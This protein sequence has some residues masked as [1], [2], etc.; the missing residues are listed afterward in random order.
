MRKFLLTAA[1]TA[2]G[3]LTVWSG[4]P[5]RSISPTS[6]GKA[7]VLNTTEH[8]IALGHKTPVVQA[9]FPVTATAPA[10]AVEVPFTHDLGKGGA[11]VKNYTSVNANNDNRKWQYGT[12]NG[13]CACMVPN[14]ADIEENDDWLF[15]VPIHLPAGSYVLGFEI[16][17]MGSGATSVRMNVGMGTEPTVEAMT[18]EVVGPTSYTKKD[19]TLYEYPVT[20]TEEGYYYLGF[21]CTTP[22]STKGTL[23]LANLSMKAGEV[24]TPADPPAA[25]QLSWVLA[26]KGELKATVTYVAPTK[27]VSG[28]DLTE[29]SKVLITSRWEV[30]K[31]EYTDVKP[32]QTIVIEDVEMYAGINNRFTAVAYVGDTPGEKVEYKS[33]WCG[34]DTPLA[35]TNV[36]LTP[37]DDYT[38]A[39]LTWDPVGEVGENGGYVDPSAVT[40]YIFD[41][42]G[43]YYDPAIAVVENG[44]TSYTFDYS[45]YTAQDFVAYQ[46]TAGYNDYYSL[47]CASN[48]V[49]V[50]KP[51][52]MPFV[53]SFTDGY[54]QNVWVM[55]QNTSYSGQDYGTVDDNYFSSLIDP[56]DPEAPT[57]L[58]SQDKDN[59][60]FYWM[61]IEKDV[62]VGMQSVR[63]NISNA[64]KPVLDFWYQGQGSTM[65]VLVAGGNKDFEVV[66]TLD[67][68]ANPTS[69]WTLCRIPLDAYKADGCVQFAFRLNAV[70]NTDTEIWSVPL[71][72]F[73]VRDLVDTDLRV[74]RMNAPEK[75]KVGETVT[76]SAPIG[77]DGAKAS[78]PTVTWTVN[79]EVLAETELEAI[80]ADGFTTAQYQYTVPVNADPVLEFRIHVE[81]QGD[82]YPDNN[83]SKII[84]EI[85]FNEYP[86]VSDLSASLRDNTVVLKW[87]EPVL[88]PTATVTVEEDFENPEYVPM[89]IT[90]AGEWTVYDGD[91]QKTYNMFREKYN[92][93]Q[94]APIGFQLFNR[95]YAEV[96]EQ[97]YIDAEPHSGET[98]MIAPSAAGALNDNWLISPRLSGKA[99]TIT[100]WAKSFS[101]AWP[102]SFELACSSTDNQVASFNNILT[103][104]KTDA[105]PEKWTEYQVALP[106]GTQYFAIHHNSYDTYGLLVDDVTYEAAP[107]MPADMALEGYHVFCNGK[108]LTDKPVKAT[109]Y[110]DTPAFS[111]SDTQ[112]FEYAV[113][114]VYNYGPSRLSNPVEVE[115]T[116]TGIESI[117]AEDA[118]ASGAQFFNLLGVRVAADR[119]TPG[120]YIRVAT[121][122]ASK[123]MVR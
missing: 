104:E 107:T 3:C 1:Y 67:L 90:G 41:A 106:E 116:T 43:S 7:R 17:Y 86:A 20:V 4:T 68:K 109:E 58:T 48:I 38:K 84:T 99:Q 82:A 26:P 103:V 69:G 97:Y 5:Q 50:G 73:S 37:S 44:A 92:P 53:E 122:R 18:T 101:S 61:P 19:M 98:F 85:K 56:E 57:P 120:V 100:F 2:L 93:F 112:H 62:M 25:G 79:G 78:T 34:P 35:P 113:A 6:S 10:N 28:A 80:P 63:V 46:V 87:S 117:T 96:P 77:N 105:V 66:R 108:Q 33:I 31:F 115:M 76:I 11:E 30:D 49:T 65:D 70:H 102:E 110:V 42:F 8:R 9:T 29:I 75:A 39:T 60:F 32:G 22:K 15:T 24:V 71:D 47:D 40:Y 89:S 16:G 72:H 114:A 12:V 81:A 45:D 123:V 94:T 83:V 64:S 23:K 27:T 36:K 21:H 118:A 52:A 55:D 74:V 13:Y 51:D 14:A 88:D 119:L 59:G 121:G 91:G 95:S 54:Y 111:A